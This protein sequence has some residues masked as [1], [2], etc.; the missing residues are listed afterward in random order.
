MEYLD[1]GCVES[2]LAPGITELT[3][4]YQGVIGEGGDNVNYSSRQ[5]ETG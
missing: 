5:G 4:G 1:G 3:N 2:N